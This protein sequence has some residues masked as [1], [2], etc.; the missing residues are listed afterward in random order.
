MVDLSN[1]QKKRV[2]DRARAR[3]LWPASDETIDQL[4]VIVEEIR[5]AGF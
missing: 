2:A 5:K 1:P 4:I 3:G